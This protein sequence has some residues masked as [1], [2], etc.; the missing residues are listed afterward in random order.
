[1]TAPRMH[2]EPRGL[3][4]DRERLVFVDDGERQGLGSHRLRAGIFDRRHDDAL[5]TEKLL[6]RLRSAARD[7]YPAGV[8]PGADAAPRVFGKQPRQ[9]LVEAQTRELGGNGELARR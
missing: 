8:D 9:R 2:D 1:M 3:V 4:D 6:L 7:A 5:A